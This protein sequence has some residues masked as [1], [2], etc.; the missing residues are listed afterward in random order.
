MGNI[1]IG[2]LQ[3]VIF[4]ALAPAIKGFIH[5]I[6]LNLRGQK[7]P[8]ILQP[9]KDLIKLFRKEPV[10]S[11]DASFISKIAPIVVLLATIISASFIPIFSPNTL[12]SFTGDV[13]AFMYV[14]GLST[15]FIALYGLDQGSSFGGLGSAR[16]MT[17]ASL[18]EPTL[19]MIMF[20][21]SLEYGTSNISEIFVKAHSHSFNVP[22][23]YVFSLLALFFVSMAENARIP[24]DNP[25]T[26]LELTMVHEAMI[27]EASGKYLAIFELS[28]YMKLLLFISIASNIFLPFLYS[29]NMLLNILFYIIKVIIFSIPIALLELSVAKFRF[30]RI[31]DLLM[32]SFALATLGFVLYYA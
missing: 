16:E 17:I 30:F 20:T 21:F 22:I 6:K 4:I 5:K 23:A 28:S 26:H 13:I 8:S 19:M 2:I 7:G 11:K 15:F 29:S 27:L 9:Y 18:A 10:I 25:E 14:L 31:P 32:I 3:I 1:V 12:L 24:F